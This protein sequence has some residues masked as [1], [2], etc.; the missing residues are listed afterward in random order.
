MTRIDLVVDSDFGS[1][2][3]FLGDVECRLTYEERSKVVKLR[4]GQAITVMGRVKEMRR[5]SVFNTVLI[6]DCQIVSEN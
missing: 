6:N 3:F 5:W 2:D 4:K 1:G